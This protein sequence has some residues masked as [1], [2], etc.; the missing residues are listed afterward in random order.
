MP[1]GSTVEFDRFVGTVCHVAPP[2]VEAIT[3]A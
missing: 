2:S 1:L 3:L